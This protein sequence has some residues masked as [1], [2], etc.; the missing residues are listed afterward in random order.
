MN[1]VLTGGSGFVGSALLRQAANHGG[2]SMKVLV[3]QPL[4]IS[5]PF[6][7]EVKGDLFH[8]PSH[9]WFDEPYVLVHYATKQVDKD[10]SGF[11]YNNVRGTRQLLA[12]MQG[13]CIGAI[14]GSSMSVYGDG[15]QYMVKDSCPLRPETPLAKSRAAAEQLIHEAMKEKARHSFTLRPRFIIG[16]GDRYTMKV[17]MQLAN[18]GIQINHGKQRF[19]LIDV[20]DYARIILS[21]CG[22]IKSGNVELQQR[23]LH[24]GYQQPI[25]YNEWMR[26]IAIVTQCDWPRK[27]WYA[28]AALIRLLHYFPFGRI[29][30]FVTKAGLLGLEHSADTKPLYD[31]ASAVIRKTAITAVHDACR[32]IYTLKKEY[33]ETHNQYQ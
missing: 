29:P 33:N 22:H 2:I 7:E 11:E 4:T 23:P 17:M 28:P 5:Y 25:S 15:I 12:S 10:G 26:T 18:N 13:N 19:N 30:Q 6:V 16:E 21:L 3:R 24:I 27:R 8:I 31:L 1:I 14:Y 9:L 20:E 32:A